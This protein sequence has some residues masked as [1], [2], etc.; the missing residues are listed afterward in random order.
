VAGEAC[1]S[2]GQICTYHL[3]TDLGLQG[4]KLECASK[5][6][7]EERSLCPEQA[8]MDGS[9]CEEHLLSCYY[10]SCPEMPGHEKLAHCSN[11]EWIVTDWCAAAGE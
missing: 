1:A 5:G 6:S 9:L 8:P 11:W 2:P 4:H 10:D 7:W 3:E